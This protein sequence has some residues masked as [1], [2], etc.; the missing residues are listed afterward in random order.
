MPQRNVGTL[1]IG[2]LPH[3]LHLPLLATAPIQGEIHFNRE[4]GSQDLFFCSLIIDAQVFAIDWEATLPGQILSSEL[5][6]ALLYLPRGES[7]TVYV[8]PT[9][10]GGSVLQFQTEITNIR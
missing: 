10:E 2:T 5:T 1:T 3:T 6:Q 4:P 9:K 7:T 8:T